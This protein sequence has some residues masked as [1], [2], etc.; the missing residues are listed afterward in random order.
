MVFTKGGLFLW[1]T[2]IFIALIFALR[3]FAWK[4]IMNSL[5][6]REESI[7]EALDSAEKAKEEMSK[8][9]ADNQKL[10][11]E[12]RLEKDKILKAARDV[13]NSIK[14]EAHTEASTQTDKM[15]SFI[16]PLIPSILW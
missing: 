8:L 12:A 13:A 6:I 11:E 14:E 7:Q 15:I 1:Q 3:K 16:L 5:K 9:Q 2:I 10:L 4:P